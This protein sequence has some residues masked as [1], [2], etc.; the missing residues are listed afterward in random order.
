MILCEQCGSPIS[1]AVHHGHEVDDPPPAPKVV[2]LSDI[3]LK[4]PAASTAPA[5]VPLVVQRSGPPPSPPSSASSSKGPSE[6][7]KSKVRKKP[8]EPWHLR[9]HK[10]RLVVRRAIYCQVPGISRVRAEAIV[11]AYPTISALMQADLK[12]IAAIRI[13]NAPLGMGLAEALKRVFE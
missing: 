7:S 5:V 13:K 1:G 12:A 6:P 2:T 3:N 4:R 9:L 11:T 8:L 10:Q